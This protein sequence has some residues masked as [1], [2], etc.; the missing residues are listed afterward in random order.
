MP[1]FLSVFGAAALADEGASAGLVRAGTDCGFF[2]HVVVKL[3]EC[4]R[5]ER[6]VAVFEAVEADAERLQGAVEGGSQ[7]VQP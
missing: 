3:Q 7:L 6:Y 1:T 2:G 5:Q 4:H